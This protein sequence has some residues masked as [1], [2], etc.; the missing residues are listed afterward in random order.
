MILNKILIVFVLTFQFSICWSQQD[1]TYYITQAITNS[2]LIKD[3]R[4]LSDAAKIEAERLKAFYT[5]PQISLIGNYMV[6]PVISTNNGKNVLVLNPDNPTN[7]NGYDLAA[8]NGGMYQG[9]LNI[10]QSLF[11]GV[12]SR[13]ATEQVMVTSQINENLIKLTTHDIEKFV[14][15][16]YILCLQDNRQMT[17][18]NTLIAIIK[19]QKGIITKATT[20]GI[21]KQSDLSLIIIEYK[22]QVN[23]WNT[24]N[25]TY[26]R[27]LM[28]LNILC[29]INDTAY[30]ILPE[31]NLQLKQD[32]IVSSSAFT[33]R[34]KL[35]SLN[36]RATQ[37]MF[38]LKY[39]PQ[40]N[41]YAN[42][43]LN[44]VYIP[45]APNRFGASAGISFTM[46]LYDGKQ[47]AFNNKKTEILIRSTQS[48]S[49]IFITQN[50]V[51]KSKALIEIR[52]L[53]ER[54]VVAESQLEEYK[55]LMDYYRKEVLTG[56]LSVVIYIN[57]LKNL[58]MLQR[59]YVLMQ[60][61]KQLLI[62]TY[63]YWNW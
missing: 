10:N 49:T 31:I 35:D 22:N 25:A 44:G 6:A 28:D 32:D 59:D 52:M 7:Y 46:N 23:A 54:M 15:D 18:L 34:Y 55:K 4:N 61:N 48:Y 33:K 1:L 37:K 53:D 43:G 60:A 38:D 3:N 11:N 30:V 42:A 2:P 19:D 36:L 45:T 17:Y 24:F 14:T 13:A 12:R 16:Q 8:S 57:I 50:A 41:L 39:K 63:N 9:L 5:K 47:R 56:Q 40:L 58:A 62:N 26:R 27:D 29:G 51:R 21:A 20:S